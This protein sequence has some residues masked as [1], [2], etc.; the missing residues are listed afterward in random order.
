VARHRRPLHV[1]A[2]AELLA[3]DPEHWAGTDGPVPG[4]S[5]LVWSTPFT[6]WQDARRAYARDHPGSELGT[7]L[8]QLRYERWVRQLRA[9]W[10]SGRTDDDL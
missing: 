4:S 5:G 10:A 7:V 9:E 8:D 6:R 3:F 1:A 2:P